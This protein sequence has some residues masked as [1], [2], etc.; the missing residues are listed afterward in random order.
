MIAPTA[1]IRGAGISVG[2]PIFEVEGATG[3]YDSNLMN[4]A[5]KTVELIS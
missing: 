5:K 4:K 2:I 3:F 1:I